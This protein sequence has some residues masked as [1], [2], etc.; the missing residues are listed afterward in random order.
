M[1]S[2]EGRIVKVTNVSGANPTVDVTSLS[3]GSY[4]MELYNPK[5]GKRFYTQFSKQ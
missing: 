3:V 1:Y 2:T 4:F 5:S